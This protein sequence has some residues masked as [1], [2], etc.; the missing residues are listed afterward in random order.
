MAALSIAI[1]QTAT[2]LNRERQQR[3]ELRL[4]EL[5]KVD[6]IADDYALSDRHGD[7]AMER[8]FAT[9][10]ALVDTE[11]EKEAVAAAFATWMKTERDEEA[12]VVGSV[13]STRSFMADNNPAFIDGAFV[14]GGSDGAA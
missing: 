1:R 7:L 6:G 5:I 8:R 12:S 4:E 14:P 2:R 11:A 3:A 13:K 10:Y 9:L